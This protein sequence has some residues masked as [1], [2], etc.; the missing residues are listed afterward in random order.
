MRLRW[1]DKL[2]IAHKVYLEPVAITAIGVQAGKSCLRTVSRYC[3][4]AALEKLVRD[5]YPLDTVSPKLFNELRRAV[6][7]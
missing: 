2:R 5:G 1:S 4:I 6:T 7:S 3:R